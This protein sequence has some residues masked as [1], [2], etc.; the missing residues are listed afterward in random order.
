ML[1]TI[2][3]NISGTL[4]LYE[5]DDEVRI[6]RVQ[7]AMAIFPRPAQLGMRQYKGTRWREMQ[8]AQFM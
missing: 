3:A 8:V 4:G 2:N 7:S 5:D 6:T 1:S